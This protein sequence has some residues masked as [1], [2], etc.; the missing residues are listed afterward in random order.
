MGGTL[1]KEVYAGKPGFKA[2]MGDWEHPGE[3]RTVVVSTTLGPLQTPLLG[4]TIFLGRSDQMHI[5]LAHSTPPCNKALGRNKDI[6]NS[7]TF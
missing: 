7:R 1:R 4:Y 6:N 5:W 2:S 3:E